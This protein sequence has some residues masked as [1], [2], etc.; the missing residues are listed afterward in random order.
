MDAA[1]LGDRLPEGAQ[2]PLPR[3]TL[4]AV[5]A[6]RELESWA[7]RVS[8]LWD[9]VTVPT[10]CAS[11][12]FGGRQKGVQQ[13]F[14]TQTFRVHWLGIDVWVQIEYGFDC[15]QVLCISCQASEPIRQKHYSAEKVGF[16]PIP[17]RVSKSAENR[18]SCIKNAQKVRKNGGFPHFLALFVESAGTPLFLQINVFAVWALRLDRKYTIQVR[19]PEGPTIK[20]I[21]SRSKFSISI[22]IFDL[23]RKF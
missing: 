13:Q 9:A 15:F 17:E 5:L 16:P 23:A 19:F 22:E 18:T 1:V 12:A 8:I 6:L 11:G 4:F 7:C 14:A 20:K 21:W 3:Q 2:K 10:V